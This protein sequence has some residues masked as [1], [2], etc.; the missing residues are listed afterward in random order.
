MSIQELTE[1]EIEALVGVRHPMTG[2]E[3]PANGLQP[4]YHWLVRTLHLLGETSGGALKIHRDDTNDTTVRVVAGRATLNGNVLVYAGESIDLAVFNNDTV[5]L[6]LYDNTGIASIGMASAT[7]GWPISAHIKLGEV[8]LSV[9]AI[10]NV[11]DR[12]HETIV[13]KGLELAVSSSLVSYSLEITSQGNLST[14]S[15]VTI[16]LQDVYGNTVAETDYLRVRICNMDA[17]VNASNATIAA[18]ANTVAEEIVTANKD[19]I[20]KSHIDGTFQLDV[21]NNVAE[22]VVL[23]IGQAPVSGRRGEYTAILNITHA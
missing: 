16:I 23:R 3:Y 13:S 12:R 9:G 20:F 15:I 4:Y 7:A 5:Y 6:W 19:L 2:F 14:P 17:Y 11:L 1:S 8:V 10:I 22:T 21:T 18:G